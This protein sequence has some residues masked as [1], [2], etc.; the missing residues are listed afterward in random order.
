MLVAA[1]MLAGVLTVRSA[2]R[3][4]QS[5]AQLR[6]S[7]VVVS[8]PTLFDRLAIPGAFAFLVVGTVTN[9]HPAAWTAFAVTMVL[10]YGVLGLTADLALRFILRRRRRSGPT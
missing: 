5:Q 4:H 6:R 8:S 7:G 10:T 2:V 3:H 1:L 9:S